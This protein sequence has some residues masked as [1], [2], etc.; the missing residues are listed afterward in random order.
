MHPNVWHQEFPVQ[1][2]A[3]PEVYDAVL[4][5]S[6]EINTEVGKP[7]LTVRMRHIY[8][9]VDRPDDDAIVYVV[10]SNTSTGSCKVRKTRAFLAYTQYWFR[11]N[12]YYSSIVL[13]NQ[14]LTTSP[15]MRAV[16]KHELLHALGLKHSESQEDVMYSEFGPGSIPTRISEEDLKVLR[17]L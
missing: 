16:V 12:K 1:V 10:V 6:D 13:C 14:R 4:D 8:E 11:R 17:D 15:Q 2:V 3:P 7:L 9:T 5:M